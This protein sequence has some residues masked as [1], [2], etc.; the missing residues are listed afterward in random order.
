M[1]A[2][3]NIRQGLTEALDYA[4]GKPGDAVTHEVTVP[5]DE[6]RGMEERQAIGAHDL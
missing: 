2:C 3:D 1:S 6:E 5:C 4:Q